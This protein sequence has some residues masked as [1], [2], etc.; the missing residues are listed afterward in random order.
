[1]T[2]AHLIFWHLATAVVAHMTYVNIRTVEFETKLIEKRQEAKDTKTF[3]FEKPKDFSYQAGQYAYFTLH[4]LIA[5]DER[6]NTRHF[7][8]SSSPTEDF[9]SF[10]TRMRD[11][12]GFKKTCDQFTL[13]TEV[14]LR[15][16]Q[17]D[18]AL[19]DEKTTVPQVMIAGGIGVTPYRSIIKYVADKNL[20]VPIHLINSNSTP[21]EIVFRKELNEI[22]S[23]HANIKVA[24][25]VTRPQESKE[26]W[27]GLTGRIDEKLIQ[28]LTSN[29]QNPT[30]WL[31]GPPAMVD[32]MEEVLDQLKIPP[33]RVKLEKF[34][35]Y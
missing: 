35:G 17:G 19:E 23:S 26:K 25:T 5:P 24:Y 7:T 28:S 27:T 11:T 14:I 6:G 15:G 8:L 4:A 12:S 30:Y 34:T 31:C 33:E 16:P 21:E 9:L 1:M 2:L 22:S 13:G 29:L 3:I 10:T 32:A 20:S 18:F